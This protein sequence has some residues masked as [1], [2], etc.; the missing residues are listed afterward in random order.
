MG[1]TDSRLP[2]KLYPPPTVGGRLTYISPD[3]RIALV[4][5]YANEKPP[6]DG[7]VYR[8]IRQYQHES[9]AL[10]Q[11]RWWSRLSPNKAKRLRQLT[12]QDNIYLC[13]A[14]DALLAIPGLWNGMSL[15]SLNTEVIHYLTHVKD[16]WA[17]LVNRD[18]AQMA[19][20][21]LHTVDTLQLYA[22]RACQVDRKTVKGKIL[23]GEVFT[24]FSRS[25]RATI[26]ENL[27]S[28]EACDGI[29]PSLHTF[30]RDISYLELCANAVK[31]LVVVNKQHST[32]WNALVHSFQPRRDSNGLIQTSE[33]TFRRQLGSN[34]EQIA[35]GYRQIWIY[36]MRHY[37]DM[38][39]D[40]QGGQNANPTRAKARARADESV[41]HGMA[42]LARKLGFRTPQIKAILKQ[43]PDQQI[44]RAALLKARKP[45]HY[46]YDRETFESLV[47]QIAGCFALAIP[48]DTPSV[49]LVTGRAIKLKDRCG[50]PQEQTQRLDRPFI[51]LD[52][53]HSATTLQSNLS[54]LEVRRSVYHAF[55]G[56]I[57]FQAVQGTPPT[58]SAPDEPLSPLFVPN[59][60]SRWGS[61]S[62]AEDVTERDSSGE[63]PSRRDQRSASHQERRRRQEDTQQDRQ[64]V[65]VYTS[66]PHGAL[67]L[68]NSPN[69]GFPVDE[70]VSIN[71]WESSDWEDLGPGMQ[72]N[73][74]PPA[75]SGTYSEIESQECTEIDENELDTR[76]GE[77]N[78]NLLVEE[79]QERV[80][81]GRA[82]AELE[83]GEGREEGMELDHIAREAEDAT[84]E[85]AQHEAEAQRAEQERQE[86]LDR[87][88][89]AEA[90]QR[91][92][93]E[94]QEQLERQAEYERTQREAE[95]AQQAEKE[96]QEQQERQAKYERIQ[97]EQERQAEQE[98]Q[99]QLER[100]A[101]YERTQREAEAAQQA[102]Q[103]RQEQLERQAEYERAQHEAEA[104]R[105]AKQERQEQLDRERQREAEER[106]EYERTQL[107]AEAAQQAE[108]EQQE[109]LE[110]A[111]QAEA[112]RQAEQ[113]RHEQL[114][115]ARQR[116]AKERAGQE[117]Q[118][119][120]EREGQRHESQVG[121]TL[122][123]VPSPAE[124]PEAIEV[125]P[126]VHNNEAAAEEIK[127][128]LHEMLQENAGSGTASQHTEIQER[129]IQERADTL[130][131]L[132]GKDETIP[133]S[134]GIIEGNDVSRPVTELPVDL[135]NLIARWRALDSQPVDKTATQSRRSHGR[136][137]RPGSKPVGLRKSRIMERPTHQDTIRVVTRNAAV[138]DAIR[139]MK[140]DGSGNASQ[141]IEN[142]ADNPPQS[143]PEGLWISRMKARG[144]YQDID[145]LGARDAAIAD[146]TGERVHDNAG[147][148]S[149]AEEPSGTT[150]E[151]VGTTGSGPFHGQ[152]E[153]NAADALDPE[154]AQT[155][156][157]ERQIAEES[158]FNESHLSETGA[159]VVEDIPESER[160]RTVVPLKKRKILEVSEKDE[161]RGHLKPWGRRAVKKLRNANQKQI[162]GGSSSETSQMGLSSPRRAPNV[163]DR[164][165]KVVTQLSFGQIA[166]T[167]P[168][169]TDMENQ[170]QPGYG[171]EGSAPIGNLSTNTTT[172][173]ATNTVTE[174]DPT[175]TA[176][177]VEPT[178]TVTSTAT[179]TASNASPARN[180]IVTFRV[181]EKGE[182]RITDKKVVKSDSPL[183][184][185]MIADLY[186]RDHDRNARFYDW[187]LR[188]V[189]VGECVR[190]AIDDG[191][192]TILMSFGRDLVVTRYLLKS[193]KQ[194][195]ENVGQSH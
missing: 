142:L 64:Q 135:P 151:V 80:G 88:R 124:N 144:T 29:I 68:Q 178:N 195:M 123:T 162:N 179:N 8:K 73:E 41:I 14:F 141:G 192:F 79:A 20:I 109:Q 86:Q 31:R 182:W 32:V 191:S 74:V 193:V 30:F 35:S 6:T 97:P 56:K 4:D 175:N 19:L 58:Q 25:E 111:Q 108:Q 106:A 171:L 7:E 194:L 85:R 170:Q 152:T 17:A 134:Q 174:T 102:E 76:V 180:V 44:A 50:A 47:K 114:E 139:E 21:D 11:N 148:V 130:A 53:L 116:E 22:P 181:W 67:S 103:E 99:E 190:A 149:S 96:R 83:A 128:L 70:A 115:K 23:S 168:T 137:I 101:E 43:S 184:A 188:K 95:A 187:Q 147:H 27:R 51:F 42:T 112:A 37:P 159:S 176:T 77:R 132:Q 113:E 154:Q 48:N 55:F 66:S 172:N 104:A 91:A 62:I 9:N 13:A 71:T 10:F 105:R 36:A 165:Q 40:V 69:Q 38:A 146:E 98:R 153:R 24:N 143:K 160:P 81:Q 34:D 157:V 161:Q 121:E 46:H 61:T 110:R 186:A 94:Q 120:P 39:K 65:A 119:Q 89:Q 183:E 84:R 118:E 129:V 59:D 78:Q 75:I 117:R 107:E 189:A 136:S 26:W 33:T 150:A 145:Q 18:R 87:E 125:E 163:K 131:Q 5:E 90:A 3:L 169:P 72:G 82:L 15:G 63:A 60:G 54:S 127:G 12:S 122:T 167:N 1:N 173:T 138:A 52:Q 57:S 49:A 158:L 45:D 177:E 92:E 133:L 100:Q 166:A 126:A 155:Q 164:A 2:R 140:K 156:A 16:F 28:H 185:Q 93:Q